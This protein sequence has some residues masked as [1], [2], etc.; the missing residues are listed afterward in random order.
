MKNKNYEL[1]SHAHMVRMNHHSPKSVT[2]KKV[3]DFGPCAAATTFYLTRAPPFKRYSDLGGHL[4]L[5][6]IFLL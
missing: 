4:S 5:E 1:V 2:E 3:T 6:T